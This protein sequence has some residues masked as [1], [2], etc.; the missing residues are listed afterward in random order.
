MI[1]ITHFISNYLT[2]EMLFY[3]ALVFLIEFWE[4]ETCS[5][6][7]TFVIFKVELNSEEWG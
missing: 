6:S 2:V 5:F 7:K 4:L 1:L 3:C